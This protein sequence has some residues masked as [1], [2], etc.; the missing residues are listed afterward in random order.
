MTT[1]NRRTFLSMS[2]G[3]LA[4]IAA[5]AVARADEGQRIVESMEEQRDQ[6]LS[7][8]TT[9][10]LTDYVDA[11]V[12]EEM[13]LT[14]YTKPYGDLARSRDI[15]YIDAPRRD[16]GKVMLRH[17]R[18]LYFY[19]PAAAN[20]IRI[21]PQQRLLGQASNGDVLSTNFSRDYR[22]EHVGDETIDDASRQPRAC[23]HVN[24]VGTG[25]QAVYPRAELWVDTR[26]RRAV[27]G[28]FYASTG[29]LMKIAFYDVY[30]EVV[31]GSY[32]ATRTL[33]VDGVSSNRVTLM[34][35]IGFQKMDMPDHWFQQSFLPRF[36]KV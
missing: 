10:K 3:A 26:S 12:N 24:L 2:G 13:A 32:W 14:V 35:F 27:R 6:T 15:V 23:H 30:R 11:R 20:T 5:P 29:R 18:D 33:I 9:I 28:R 17:G 31:P 36:Q 25:P 4:A 8:R 21:S 7:M 16:A 22:A 34:D 19:D 1:F